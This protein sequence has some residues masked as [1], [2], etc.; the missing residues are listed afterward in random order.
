MSGWWG[1]SEPADPLTETTPPVPADP[2][3]AL[4]RPFGGQPVP[5]GRSDSTTLSVLSDVAKGGILNLVGAL[6]AGL[7]SFVLV[8]IVTRGLGASNAGPF[9]EA[10]AL[11]SILSNS[12]E[13]GAD[14]GLVRY[15]ARYR[16]LH[17][18]QDIDRVLLVALWP[19]LALASLAAF[20]IYAFAPALSHLFV[21]GADGEAL[22]P[23]IRVLAPF[24]PISAC[25][26][27]AVAA[28]RGFGTMIPS[29]V[30]DRIAKPSA[31]PVFVFAAIVAGMG[32]GALAL[33][34]GLPIAGA[35]LAVVIWGLS[36]RRAAERADPLRVT[37]SRAAREI[38]SEFWRF[39]A[40]RG[41]AGAF[42]I[43]VVWLD[44]LLIGGL[45]SPR[46]AGIYAAA[47]RYLIIGTFASMAIQ[48]VM[49]PKLSELLARADREHANAVYKA[50]TAWLVLLVWP[51][52]LTLAVFAPFFLQVF[53]GDFVGGSGP[54][55][56][57]SLAMLLATGI[58]PVDVVLLMGGKSRWNLANTLAAL[59]L[60]VILNVLLIP[61][62][63]I[64]G[65]AIAWSASIA[66][67]NVAPLV[68]VWRLL[69]LHPFGPALSRAALSAGACFGLLG[70]LVRYAM[71]PSAVG[72]VLL[73]L[74]G[75]ASYLMLLYCFR[76]PLQIS[77]LRE[78]IRLGR[79]GSGT[80]EVSGDGDR[81][82]RRET[83]EDGAPLGRD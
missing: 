61:H 44:T 37:P 24:V 59:V 76:A 49:A 47:T 16:V 23:Y 60:N 74:L 17:R 71:D 46:D 79:F 30:V 21:H 10:I 18:V 78:G 68:Q 29:V 19:V 40:P 66:L 13:L 32:S 14:T 28:T 50:A 33:A 73:F 35:F 4:S 3:P 52:Y 9:F 43:T 53:G 51:V 34:W 80:R 56:T 25:Y 65:A 7:A 38:A 20:L 45:R 72:F 5:S 54:L 36:L 31:Q 15:I 22:V 58:G 81:R 57:L 70:L 27:V 48:Q 12:A 69:G 26:T 63:G 67:N 64:E 55:V 75:T 11:F 83:R 6:W 2:V 82:A 62:L 1:G 42:Q 41:L 77:A 8:V 39:A